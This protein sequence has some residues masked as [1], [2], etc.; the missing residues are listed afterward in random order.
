LFNPRADAWEDHFYWER[1]VLRGKSPVASATIELLQINRPDRVD[2]RR[3]LM[4]LNLWD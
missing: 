2:H 1:A 3:L 4:Q